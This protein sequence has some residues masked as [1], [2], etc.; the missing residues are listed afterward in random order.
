[1]IACRQ[2]VTSLEEEV[3][4]EEEVSL[5]QFVALKTSPSLLVK[6]L[7]GWQMNLRDAFGVKLKGNIATFGMKPFG[8][9]MCVSKYND[10]D[11]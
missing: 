9:I 3:V 11:L 7:R 2:R 4:R 6:G 10:R 1:M 5:C 8:I